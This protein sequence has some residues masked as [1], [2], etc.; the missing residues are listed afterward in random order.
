ML[1]IF[2]LVR[3]NAQSTVAGSSPDTRLHSMETFN[4]RRVQ[5]GH[6]ELAA[7][8]RHHHCSL[9]SLMGLAPALLLLRK[10]PTSQTSPTCRNR[11]FWGESNS[12]HCL[13]PTLISGPRA[14]FPV[15]I[16]DLALVSTVFSTASLFFFYL[17]VFH[18]KNFA[19][20][21]S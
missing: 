11:P 14:A 18:Y 10:S 17:F 19:F 12:C 7:P 5:G 16:L 13:S 21:V 9:K 4:L 6:Q 20:F 3:S 1:C 8:S 2:V 15:S